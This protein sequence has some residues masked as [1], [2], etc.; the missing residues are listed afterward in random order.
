MICRH[1]PSS[2][3]RARRYWNRLYQPVLPH[4]HPRNPLLRSCNRCSGCY[5]RLASHD[6][7]HFPALITNHGDVVLSSYQE[8]PYIETIP[9]SSL[10]AIRE[11]APDDRLYRCHSCVSWR[12]SSNLACLPKL[13]ITKI[14]P[15]ID[16]LLSRPTD[17]KDRECL[18]RL[19]HLCHIYYYLHGLPC[20]NFGLAHQLFNRHLLL[21]RLRGPWR[22]LPHLST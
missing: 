11:L 16:T 19:R 8:S 1:R 10:Y 13:Q 4:G 3:Y 18:W 22:R 17:C 9:R 21:P 15:N 5:R 6:Y 12:K 2:S 7:C 20:C 14:L